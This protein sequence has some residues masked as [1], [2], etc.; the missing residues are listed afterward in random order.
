MIIFSDRVRNDSSPKSEAESA[1]EWLDRA[2]R[3]P[4]HRMRRHLESWVT[5]YP[6]EHHTDLVASIRSSDDTQHECGLFE[7]MLHEPR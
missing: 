6:V 1:F 5:R 2:A 4:V 3:P 7:I